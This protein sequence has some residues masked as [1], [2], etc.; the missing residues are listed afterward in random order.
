MDFED[1]FG[2][3]IF[4]YADKFQNKEILNLLLQKYKNLK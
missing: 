2:E 4:S 1:E 3:T